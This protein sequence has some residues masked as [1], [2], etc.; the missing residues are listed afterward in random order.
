M[1]QNTLAVET[2]SR[3]TF[4]KH[5]TP[6]MPKFVKSGS[7]RWPGLGDLGSSEATQSM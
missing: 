5:A 2:H 6:L 4:S 7:M 1:S 3:P